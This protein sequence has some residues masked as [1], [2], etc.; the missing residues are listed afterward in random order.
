MCWFPQTI[1]PAICFCNELRIL[2][3]SRDKRRISWMNYSSACVN[4]SCMNPKMLIIS[5]MKTIFIIIRFVFNESIN[6][7]S[8]VVSNVIICNEKT[9][10]G[11]ALLPLFHQTHEYKLMVVPCSQQHYQVYM[12]QA[13]LQWNHSNAYIC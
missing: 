6:G 11:I 5:W 13:W 9:Y 8:T 10:S 3:I 1:S 7:K 2:M 4:N 12:A